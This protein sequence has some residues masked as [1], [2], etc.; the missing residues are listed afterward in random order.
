MN[1]F[2]S[3]NEL[4]RIHYLFQDKTSECKALIDSL[5][6]TEVKDANVFETTKERL[7]QQILLKPVHILEP[8]IIGDRTET[9]N[10]TFEQQVQGALREV[11]ILTVS[12]PFEGS[13]ELFNYTPMNGFS[14]SDPTVFEPSG[15][16]VEIDVALPS[17]D[18]AAALNEAKNKFSLTISIITQNNTAAAEW[19][20]SM[21]G[22]IDSE[23]DKRREELVGLY[24]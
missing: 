10:L 23:L 21:E 18:K 8:K 12:Y 11:K 3:I 24:A 16:C 22:R 17:I 4:K 9:R 20:K 1:I 13:R 7:K 5:T 19:S 15:N 6:I 2:K 14:Y